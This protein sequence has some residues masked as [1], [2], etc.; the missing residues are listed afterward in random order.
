M[1]HPF[2]SQPMMSSGSPPNMMMNKQQKQQQQVQQQQQM[3]NV[4]KPL[5]KMSTNDSDMNSMMSSS[6]LPRQQ[7]RRQSSVKQQQR[8]GNKNKT[9]SSSMLLSPEHSP[10]EPQGFMNVNPLAMS[11]PNL[12]DLIN[13]SKHSPPSYDA[14]IQAR[15]LQVGGGQ[16]TNYSL[17]NPNNFNLTNNHNR[18]QSMPASVSSN[19]SNHLSPPQS[20]LSHVHSPPHSTGALSPT[21]PS[22]MS[23]P[24][25][26]G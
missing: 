26:C 6:T 16:P 13:S 21:N 5:K 18:Q 14:A 24:Q 3:R 2:S 8:G 1:P 17:E 25:S 19:Y 15:T 22:V 4:K 11:H 20:N 12:E 9:D 7:A 23:P 10:Y